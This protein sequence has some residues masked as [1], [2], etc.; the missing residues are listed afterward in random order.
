[1]FVCPVPK[2]SRVMMKWRRRAA[3]LGRF[4]LWRNGRRVIQP[5]FIDA[6]TRSHKQFPKTVT[7][8][9]GKYEG[10]IQSK[11]LLR[12]LNWTLWQIQQPQIQQTL[13][14]CTPTKRNSTPQQTFRRWT[15]R[16]P[17]SPR[18]LARQSE[19]KRKQSPRT[20]A[21]VY[22]HKCKLERTSLIDCTGHP[23]LHRT[24]NTN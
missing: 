21:H 23:I 20:E 18:E 15:P 19:A 13:E 12:V 5:G 4:T 22:R 7:N 3:Q 9:A 11:T 10:I 24:P 14:I 17:E 1:M 6:C 16:T 2:I 8:H